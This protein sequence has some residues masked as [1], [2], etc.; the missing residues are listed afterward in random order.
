M[1]RQSKQVIAALERIRDQ[2]SHWEAA[3]DTLEAKRRDTMIA[4]AGNTAALAALRQAE[5]ILLGQ[6]PLF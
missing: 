6:E 1:A 4:L 2:I 5:H 3:R